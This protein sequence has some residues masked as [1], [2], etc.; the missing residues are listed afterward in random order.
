VTSHILSSKCIFVIK[1]KGVV[2]LSIRIT[3]VQGAFSVSLGRI[4]CFT[5]KRTFGR[6]FLY[7]RAYNL[8]DLYGAVVIFSD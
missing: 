7:A 2:Y 6:I 5:D 4:L 1:I 8:S 3:E